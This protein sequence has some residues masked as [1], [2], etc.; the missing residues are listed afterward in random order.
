MTNQR[1]PCVIAMIALVLGLL[2]SL[3][4]FMHPAAFAQDE[5]D[6]RIEIPSTF[7]PVGSGA[8]ALGMGGAFIGVADDATAASWNPGGLIQLETPEV[9]VVAA[10]V[11]RTEDLDF[12][13]DPGASG[14]QGVSF[15]S[16]NYFSAAYPFKLLNRNMIVSLNYQHLYDLNRQWDVTL[17]Q[18][19][20]EFSGKQAIDYTSDG[21]LSAIGLVY[22]VQLSP[23]FSIGMTLNFWDDGF[24]KNQWET[25]SISTR[26]GIGNGEPFQNK[27]IY[28][29]KYTNKC[30]S[31]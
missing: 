5:P 22:A 23:T 30:K 10:Y 19:I 1:R 16:L 17:T 18:S 15:G 25:E 3:C 29:T 9:S 11:H 7:N 28:Y 8:R 21:S 4:V 31:I 6:E 20:S 24:Y 26:T 2:F 12:G 27:S 13:N 14:E